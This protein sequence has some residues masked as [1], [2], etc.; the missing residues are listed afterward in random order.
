MGS[1][2]ASSGLTCSDTSTSQSFSVSSSRASD[3]PLASMRNFTWVA[4]FCVWNKLEPGTNDMRCV[5]TLC[6]KSINKSVA[7][8]LSMVTGFS[9]DKM[10]GSC[11]AVGHDHPPHATVRFKDKLVCIPKIWESHA[12]V[13][14]Q[15]VHE[16]QNTCSKGF[17][18]TLLEVST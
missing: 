2:R 17:Y 6:T 7:K 18:E 12:H 3:L 16:H 10:S 9:R 8:C 15:F 13:D 11:L 5:S 4:H 1:F 14:C